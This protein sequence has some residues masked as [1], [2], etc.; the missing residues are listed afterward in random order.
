MGGF[1]FVENYEYSNGFN[2]K[3]A[4]TFNRAN[5]FRDIPGF[6]KA[7]LLPFPEEGS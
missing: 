5:F 4:K 1:L 3:V 7:P 2:I 6:T